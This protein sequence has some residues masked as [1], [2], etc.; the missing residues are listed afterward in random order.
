[1]ERIRVLAFEGDQASVIACHT[2]INQS[3]LMG[4]LEIR[5]RDLARQPLQANELSGVSVVV[6]DPPQAGAA[7]QMP[8]IARAKVPTVIYVSCDPVSLGRDAA[9][10]QSAGYR[11]QKV[12]PI[13]QFLW[14]ARLEAVAV[15]KFGAS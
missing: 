12:T 9:V 15:F 13:D 8:F 4:K 14:S 3:G 1:V 7:A 5:R 11:L 2:G 6:L 10:L